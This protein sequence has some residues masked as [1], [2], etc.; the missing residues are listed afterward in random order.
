[1]TRQPHAPYT[2]AHHARG[3][4][5]LLQQQVSQGRE[6]RGRGCRG[7][8]SMHP[9]LDGCRDRGRKEM[10][11]PKCPRGPLSLGDKQGLSP[12]ALGQ[13]PLD[14]DVSG[15]WLWC[16]DPVPQ[17]GMAGGP[18]SPKKGQLRGPCAPERDGWGSSRQGQLRGPCTLGRDN[19]GGPC[20][21]G[22]DVGGNP[23]PQERSDPAPCWKEQPG[24]PRSPRRVQ[25]REDLA[26]GRG[27]LVFPVPPSPHPMSPCGAS[28]TSGSPGMCVATVPVPCR[29]VQLVQLVLHVE[30][31][32]AHPLQHPLHP[33]CAGP[34]GTG[35]LRQGR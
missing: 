13:L 16:G 22:R 28:P 27:W 7:G 30:Q 32:P 3:A 14:R 8:P 33:R 20:P 29:P 5:H 24:V 23:D 17:K 2:H 1:M 15:L 34:C 35:K 21:T 18:L 4:P 11:T 12:N 19:L 25:P 6:Q 31:G 26:S 9:L 10:G